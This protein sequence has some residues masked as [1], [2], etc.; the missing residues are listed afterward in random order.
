[1]S[2]LVR[3]PTRIAI[4]PAAIAAIGTS[5]SLLLVGGSSAAVHAQAAGV[6]A[7]Q[8]GSTTAA[9]QLAAALP[10]ATPPTG[11]PATIADVTP[12]SHGSVVIPAAP[13]AHPA[14]AP[15]SAGAESKTATTRKSG[16]GAAAPAGVSISSND[17]IAQAVFASVNA[18]RRANGLPALAWNSGLQRSAHAHNLAMAAADTLSHQL[19]GE[20]SFG[21]RETAQGVHWT[22]AAENIGCTSQLSSAGALGLENAMMAEPAGQ[23]NHR[24]NILSASSDVIGI[25]V[26]LDSA[27]DTLW[28]TEDFAHI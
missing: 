23:A 26:V 22:S 4:A 27:H 3:M 20:A 5:I 14:L 17:P 15:V 28:L 19:P 2:R 16:S 9:A 1:M 24:G 21:A 13:P 6:Q 8:P 25:D 18:S 11:A 12:T 10:T 7:H